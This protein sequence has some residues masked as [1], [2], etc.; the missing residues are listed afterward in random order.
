MKNYFEI[1]LFGFKLL[2]T[3]LDFISNSSTVRWTTVRSVKTL[4]LPFKVQNSEMR[5]GE[6]EGEGEF[7]KRKNSV[8][9]QKHFTLIHK[10]HTHKQTEIHNRFSCI[11]VTETFSST[12][13][14][15]R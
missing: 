6:W 12:N 4:F 2:E 1:N 5:G 8:P 14:N 15:E 10:K 3:I 9:L 7:V 11:V 13:H